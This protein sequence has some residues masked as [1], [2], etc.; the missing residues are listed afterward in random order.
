MQKRKGQGRAENKILWKITCN[1]G[2]CV[3]F[4]PLCADASIDVSLALCAQRGVKDQNKKS[5]RPE[6]RRRELKELKGQ[7]NTK[8][9][10]RCGRC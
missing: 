4:Y 2:S 10:E 6:H 1:S 8:E 3:P 7:T 9:N 5:V